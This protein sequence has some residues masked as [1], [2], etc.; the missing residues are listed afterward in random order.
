MSHGHDDRAEEHGFDVRPI[1]Q[2][3]SFV[4]RSSGSDPAASGSSAKALPVD[5]TMASSGKRRKLHDPTLVMPGGRPALDSSEDDSLAGRESARERY[6][7]PTVERENYEIL[8]EV[9]VGGIGRIRRAREDR[10]GRPVALKELRGE[11][12]LRVEAR[13]VR[14]ALITARLQHP[15]II[16]IYEA[17][18]WP[19]GELFYAMKLV[20]GRS[21]A[22]V[23]EGRSY[24]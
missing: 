22:E 21:L 15:S 4:T 19:S 7:L 2:G 6:R 8:G 13:F 12:D 11:A 23:L 16:P 9:A 1:D 5:A 14:E 17:G 18:R 10:L 24:A 3:V 20:A